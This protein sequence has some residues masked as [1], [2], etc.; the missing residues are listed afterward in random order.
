MAHSKTPRPHL[1]QQPHSSHSRAAKEA[2]HACSAG[3]AS[4]RQC[5][6]PVECVD[7]IFCI[8]L[9]LVVHEAEAWRRSGGRGG[10]RRGGWSEG[11]WV[12]HRMPGS[13]KREALHK[14]CSDGSTLERHVFL[15]EPP[16][17]Q[18]PLCC[19]ENWRVD[20]EG[21]CAGSRHGWRKCNC[22]FSGCDETAHMM[23]GRWPADGNVG[24]TG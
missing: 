16:L 11:G 4:A 6:P 8:S 9:V 3:Q 23:A 22:W 15:S 14:M 12:M 18:V 13:V 17:L 19:T 2:G 1:A 21:R 20:C 10:R 7:G 5:F 24:G